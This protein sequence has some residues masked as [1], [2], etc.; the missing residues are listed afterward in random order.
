[1]TSVFDL[2]ERVHLEDAIDQLHDQGIYDFYDA[3]EPRT[4]PD[5]G[6][7]N[8]KLVLH[9]KSHTPRS[10][11]NFNPIERYDSFL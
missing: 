10:C 1:M 11:K 9:C 6:F 4:P 7:T 2:I 8:L 3:L 5:K